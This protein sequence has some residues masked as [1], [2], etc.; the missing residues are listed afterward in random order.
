MNKQMVLVVGGPGGSGS[1]TI[2]KMLSEHFSLRRLYG[3]DFFRREAGKRGFT[4]IEDFLNSVS[5]EE[6]KELDKSVDETLREYARKGGV[7]IESKVFAGI[8][9]KEDIEC[10]AK[11]WL[12][13][14]L[15]VRTERTLGKENVCN[16]I[17]KFLRRREIKKNLKKRYEFDRKRYKDIYDLDYD[18]Q[19]KYNDL[20]VNSS[21]QTPEQTFNFILEFLKN[22]RSE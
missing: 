20:V 10:D 2:S 4:Q 14:S 15:D 9:T 19:E 1:S 5:I 21:E 6:I 8:A 12:N 11:I 13:A 18:K 16:F 3:G 7:L 22:G 17:Q